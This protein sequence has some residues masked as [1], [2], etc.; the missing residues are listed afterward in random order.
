MIKHTYLIKRMLPLPKKLG[1][2]MK[3]F[4]FCLSLFFTCQLEAQDNKLKKITLDKFGFEE[5]SIPVEGDTIYFYVHQKKQASPNKVV[6]YLQGTSPIPEPFFKVDK[7]KEGFSYV[8]YFPQDYEFLNEEYLFVII[9][10]PGTP[11][12][13]GDGSL[14]NLDKYNRL[15]SLDYRVFAA[16]TVINYIVTNLFKP[17]KTIVYGHSE[18][19]FVVPKL[20]TVNNKVTHL[21]VWG[22]SALPDFYDFILFDRKSNWRGEQSDSIT[23]ENISLIIEQF[24]SISLDTLNTV[25]SN[26]N[27]IAEYTNKRWWSYAEPSINHLLKIDIPIYIQLGTEDE[28]SPIESNYLI[29]LEF[30]RLGKK[31]LSFNVC[32]GC[33]HGFVHVKTQKDHWSDIFKNFIDWTQEH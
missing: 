20:A 33:D 24:K 29:P 11:A 6:V 7:I 19:A 26:K 16:D 2:P 31:N 3:F 17:K 32:V 21:G 25:P 8:S 27:E 30:A 15:N 13:E 28:S 18:G 1:L 14:L 4:I 5:H 9:G 10:L 23:Q 22:G 12:V